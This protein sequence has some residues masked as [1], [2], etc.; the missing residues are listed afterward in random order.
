MTDESE[1]E[2]EGEF[3][4]W[5]KNVPQ[6]EVFKYYK[7]GACAARDWILEKARENGYDPLMQTKS[8]PWEGP[9]VVIKK[10]EE[11]CK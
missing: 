2:K 8:R 11:I 4:K 5:L 10:L 3:E 1:F 6:D 7:A 9:V